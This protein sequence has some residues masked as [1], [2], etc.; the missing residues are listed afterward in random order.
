MPVQTQK[1]SHPVPCSFMG[2]PPFIHPF[3]YSLILSPALSRNHRVK[4]DLDELSGQ[5]GVEGRMERRKW[6]LA[7]A[8]D[9]QTARHI[10]VPCRHGLPQFDSHHGILLKV[11]LSALMGQK[12]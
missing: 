3:V 10:L 2:S 4:S 11:I 9:L 1:T 5:P 12:P 6:G 8:E 7:F